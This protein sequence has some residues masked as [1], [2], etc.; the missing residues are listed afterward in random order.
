MIVETKEPKFSKKE[1]KGIYLLLAFRYM[2]ALNKSK[3]HADFLKHYSM[4][5]SFFMCSSLGEVLYDMFGS[6]YDV[7]T[8]FP[9]LML[10]E[11]THS[12]MNEVLLNRASTGGG[13]FSVDTIEGFNERVQTLLFCAEMC[14]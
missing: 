9:E 7:S 10:F 6:G 14:K 13:W 2:R 12:E 5:Y 4:K 11:P 8:E 1:R 3:T